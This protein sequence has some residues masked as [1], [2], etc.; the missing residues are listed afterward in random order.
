MFSSKRTNARSDLKNALEG[1]QHQPW[2]EVGHCFNK[3]REFE[4]KNNSNNLNSF[5]SSPGWSSGHQVITWSSPRLVIRSSGHPQVG[6]Q[7]IRSSL[8]RPQVGHQ[9]IR[10]SLGHPHETAQVIRSSLVMPTFCDAGALIWNPVWRG[11]RDW[12]CA[13]KVFPFWF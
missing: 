12:S 7:V 3:I 8:G 11:R 4:Q 9:V 6:H 10:S 5:R 1:P 2:S 13:A